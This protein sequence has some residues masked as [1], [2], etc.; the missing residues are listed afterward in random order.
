MSPELSLFY[1]GTSPPTPILPP[2]LEALKGMFRSNSAAAR[3]MA[4]HKLTGGTEM[5]DQSFPS[6]SP[7]P[8]PGG[9]ARNNT[10]AGGERLAARK[11]MLRRL[12]ERIKEVDPE[13]TSGG[14]D[15][16]T[17]TPP[18]RR[19]RRSR[20][21]S[22]GNAAVSDSDFVPTSP[23]TPVV[24]SA[25]LPTAPDN[26]PEPLPP[27][28]RASSATPSQHI[29]PPNESTE[30]APGG[31]GPSESGLR[32]R[33]VLVEEDDVPEETI[34]PQPHFSGLPGTPQ[35]L[36][37]H[38]AS[39]RMPHGSDAPSTTSTNST[40]PTAIGV[41]VYSPSAGT[42][43]RHDLFSASPFRPPLNERPSGDDDEEQVLYQAENHPQ[44]GQYRDAFDR[45]I[46][47]VADPGELLC[48]LCHGLKLNYTSS[49]PRVR[50]PYA[51]S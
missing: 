3:M 50:V 24:P 27:P 10:V 45:E 13:Q 32:R 6:P 44:R 47:W 9:L 40:S 8:P 39:M 49:S 41:P 23:N 26:I 28:P 14:E 11:F 31:Q 20:R 4:M 17:H 12:G 51:Y 15:V 18:K 46:S 5:Y 48:T 33:S 16:A 37:T 22:A 38:V 34:P 7:T 21:S 1:P 19:R 43:P 36:H 2:S 42:P 35:H 29:N 30:Q 25:P